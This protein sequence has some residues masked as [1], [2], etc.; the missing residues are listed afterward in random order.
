MEDWV[1][2]LVLNA[3]K[4]LQANESMW[5][6]LRALPGTMTGP[7]MGRCGLDGEKVEVNRVELW[8][9]KI[10]IV[11]VS[12]ALLIV[13]NCRCKLRGNSETQTNF[14]TQEISFIQSC[15][16]VIHRCFI[17]LLYTGDRWIYSQEHDSW[18]QLNFWAR[19]CLSSAGPSFLGALV[20]VCV[21]L[22]WDGI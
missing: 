20:F 18:D 12:S 5:L 2:W 21:C 13:K 22:G 15:S 1:D 16:T 9:C 3:Q 7:V 14:K 6:V 11:S 8:W 10:M 4:T 19:H 17:L